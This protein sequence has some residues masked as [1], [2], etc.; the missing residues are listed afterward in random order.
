ME[1][2]DSS[3]PNRFLTRFL[4]PV[5]CALAGG[6]AF[7]YGF[8]GSVR[9]MAV[10]ISAMAALWGACLFYSIGVL[11]KALF[12]IFGFSFIINPRT[13]FGIG[14]SNLFN[15]TYGNAAYQ[16]IS[17]IEIV[18]GALFVLMMLNQFAGARRRFRL[19]LPK[20]TKWAILGYSAVAAASYTYAPDSGR[21]L[22][23][24]TFDAKIL[25]IILFLS[26]VFSDREWVYAYLPVF[27]YGLAAAAGFES[28]LA[29]M[30]YF[31]VL[32][33]RGTFIG[34]SFG[35]GVTEGMMGGSMYR[36]TGTF[37]HPGYLGVAMSAAALL[38]WAALLS[39]KPIVKHKA[40]LWGVWGGAAFTILATSSRASWLGLTI[41]GFFY[42]LVSVK[43]QGRTWIYDFMKKYAALFLL[44]CMML[45]VMFWG[46]LMQRFYQSD[47]V[48]MDS[49]VIL[50]NATKSR[51]ARAPLFGGG[52]GNHIPLLRMHP[53]VKEIRRATKVPMPVENSY[54]LWM[55]EVG[56]VGSF[57][58]LMIPA[59]VFLAAIR[60]CLRHRNDELAPLCLAF[61][62]TFILFWISDDF[63]PLTRQVDCGYLYG[64]MIAVT[65]GLQAVLGTKHEDW[66]AEP[67]LVRL[68][69]VERVECLAER[70]A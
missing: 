69:H 29:M 54:L 28:V 51:I 21:A 42:L 38:L 62:T 68:V 2:F 41:C 49:R 64:M 15:L 30:E 23:Q 33:Y 34:L 48:A 45:V 57:F 35:M 7:A 67:V 53:D 55:S 43:V 18:F 4:L 36:V 5:C 17:T 13:F 31:N 65:T 22:S 37:G 9:A 46:A 58:Y 3:H 24:M 14:T 8:S 26:H 66:D 56:I 63:S 44:A 11:Q 47:A 12:F 32:P 60:S 40:L 25:V 1:L 52:I 16:F 50:A 61:A 20:W 10:A 39:A 27:L 19:V 70:P 6:Y 59:T